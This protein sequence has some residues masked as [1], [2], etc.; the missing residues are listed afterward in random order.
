MVA[1]GQVILKLVIK[2][3]Y[4]AV[5]LSQC[6]VDRLTLFLVADHGTYCYLFWHFDCFRRFTSSIGGKFF[7]ELGT[8]LVNGRFT[9]SE[10]LRERFSFI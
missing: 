6:G 4:E 9:I 2:L 1:A 10:W 5:E 3:H 8:Y 7:V